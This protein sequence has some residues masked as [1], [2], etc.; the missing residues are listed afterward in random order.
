MAGKVDHCT[1][2]AQSNTEERNIILPYVPDCGDLPFDA[3]LAESRG[4]K[5]TADPLEVLLRAGALDIL[6]AN[7]R[8]IHLY[9]VRSAGV[10]ERLGNVFGDLPHL[11]SIIVSG[12]SVGAE[13]FEACLAAASASLQ[14][15][16]K[17]SRR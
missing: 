7:P 16:A 9:I 5:Q 14:V 12:S 10:Y 17:A 11:R 15:L 8:E 1:L 13:S 3:A 6:G 2:K 4:D